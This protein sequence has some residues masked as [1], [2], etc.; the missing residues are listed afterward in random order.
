MISSSRA[1]PGRPGGHGGKLTSPQKRALVPGTCARSQIARMRGDR[2]V[3][4][5]PAPRTQVDLGERAVGDDVRALAAAHGADVDGGPVIEVGE[6]VQRGHLLS[7]V[8]DGAGAQLGL[9]P[10]VRGLARHLEVEGARAL[11]RHHVLAAGARGL[12]DAHAVGAARLRPDDLA[13]GRRQPLLVG[14]E[15]D[16]HVRLRPRARARLLVRAQRVEQRRRARPSCRRRRGP[17]RGPGRRCGTGA[18]WPCPTGTRCRSGRRR[19]TAWV[20]GPACR[21]PGG[22]RS[23]R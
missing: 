17:R 20:P 10:G 21:R 12:E 23:G 22:R 11:A 1:V 16:A 3:G 8:P 7:Q 5:R 4:R 14:V 2:R 9:Q 18:A 13:R 6:R 15:D 19:G